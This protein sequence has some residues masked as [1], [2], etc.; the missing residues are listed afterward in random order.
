[1]DAVFTIDQDLVTNAVRTLSLQTLSA[2]SNGILLNWNDAELAVYLVYIF[3]EIVKS[4]PYL[5]VTTQA[6]SHDS[7]SQLEERA[8]RLFAS[9]PSCQRRNAAK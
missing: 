8:A 2:Y 7:I 6:S 3:G 5:T 1:M 9:L 4:R